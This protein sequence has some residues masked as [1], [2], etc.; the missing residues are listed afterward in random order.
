M[1]AELYLLWLAIHVELELYYWTDSMVCRTV[2]RERQIGN[3]KHLV[4]ILSAPTLHLIQL[5]LL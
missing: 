3:R 5:K 1:K 4:F 2:C